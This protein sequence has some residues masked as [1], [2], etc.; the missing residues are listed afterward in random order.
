MHAVSSSKHPITARKCL[1]NDPSNSW[2]AILALLAF[3]GFAHGMAASG[4]AGEVRLAEHGR[5]L[6]VIVAPAEVMQW[7]AAEIHRH[8]PHMIRL[9]ERSRHLQRDS[10]LD[11][12]NYLG[13]ISGTTMEITDTL[14]ADDDR[15]PIY[16]A[17]AAEEIFGPVGISKADKFGFRVVVDGRRGIGLYGES[18]YGTSYAIYEL[19][20]RM[21]CRWFMPSSLGE[22]IPETSTLTIDV[23]DQ[24]L[25]PATEFRGI[26]GRTADHDFL[27]RNRLGGNHLEQRHI[28]GSYITEEQLEANPDWRLHIDGRPQRRG[29]RW[30]REDVAH[31]VA[32]RIIELLDADYQPSI[33]LSPEDRVVPTEDPEEMKH[34]PEPRVWEPAAGRWSVTDRLMML[35]NRVAERVGE[36]YPDVIYG[37]LAYVNFNM[38]PA[39]EPVHP[40]IVPVIAPIDFNRHHPMTW[41]DHPNEFWLRDMVEGWGKVAERVAYYAYGMNLAEITAPNP[42][43]TKW[44]TDIPII[45]ENN[46]AFW[47][48][49]TM[50]GWENMLPGFYLSIRMTFYPD[51][52]P[53]DILQDLWTRFYGAA[54]EPMAAYWHHIDRAWIETREYAGSGFGYLR[55][56]TP[57][58]MAEAR[59]L[60]DQA[61]AQ[62]ETIDE[63]RR[64]KLID[65]SLAL[66]ELFMKM[67]E[68]FAAADF[69]NL[70]TDLEEWR[71]TLAHLRNR[72]REQYSFDTPRHGAA[73]IGRHYFDYQWGNAYKDAAR[74]NQTYARHG[75]PMLEWQ[76]KHNPDAE[77]TSRP[78]VAPDYD[79]GDWPSKHVVRDTW[80]SIGHHNTLTDQASGASGRM[81]YRASQRLRALPEGKRAYLW[82]GSTDGS[83]KVY[84]NGEHV[85]YVV[86]DGQRHAGE[87]RD[88][89]SGYC[90]PA[91]YDVTDLLK[92]G[93]NHFAIKTERFRLNELGTGGLMGP[94]MIYRER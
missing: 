3:A 51:E 85:P 38:P 61:L 52:K 11:L 31:A 64:V 90:R 87:I 24:R 8:T 65:E 4:G 53:E 39:R 13:R 63:Y 84:V 27:R 60:I 75:R 49:E 26:Q 6:T 74:M 56:F 73:G 54:A 89:F 76:W 78:W 46:C 45:L 5:A 42:F 94:V 32:D 59:A 77:E 34:D 58:V 50:G 28:L 15:I 79:A 17:G 40:N 19:L 30:T 22:V 29:Y 57:D 21:G 68:D 10:V 82:I 37:M 7:E 9:A 93:D 1:M 88:R 69:R 67:R 72:Y 16:I 91:K 35:A 36:K 62:C 47:T 33:S 48:P 14:A 83:A 18:E 44:S 43:I 25:A 23:M 92:N 80:S 20:H 12:A 41:Q 81:V 2:I 66:F 55:M 86:P 70:E 71:G